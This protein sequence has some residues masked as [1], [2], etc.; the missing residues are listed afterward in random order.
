MFLSKHFERQNL[1]Q[2]K[3]TVRP[4]AAWAN[5]EADA[6]MHLKLIDVPEGITNA[7]EIGCGL[8]RLLKQL[9]GIDVHGIDA[10]KSML[11]EAKNYAPKATV[12]WCDGSGSI[13]YEDECFDFVF[14]IIVFQHIPDT[15][16]VQRYLTEAHRVLRPGGR[17]HFQVLDHEMG[18]GPLWTYHPI[19]KLRESLAGFDLVTNIR[20]NLWQLFRCKK[21]LA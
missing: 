3:L 4:R 17:L 8:G 10:S 13:P 6:R 15:A 20:I 14:S 21:P 2:L 11:A 18:R 9:D 5:I 19:G 16:A 7:L 12:K 1:E